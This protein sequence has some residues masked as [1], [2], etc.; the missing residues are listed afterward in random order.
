MIA[1]VI[2]WGAC[3]I[4]Y[5]VVPDPHDFPHGIN[6]QVGERVELVSWDAIKRPDGYPDLDKVRVLL[7]R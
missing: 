3:T 4:R 7:C 1:A 5:I 2:I 6:R